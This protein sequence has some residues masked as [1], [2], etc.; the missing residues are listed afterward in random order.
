MG[1]SS[2]R[3]KSGDTP[4]ILVSALLHSVIAFLFVRLQTAVPRPHPATILGPLARNLFVRI[5]LALRRG[6]IALRVV[7]PVVAFRL[8]HRFPPS[9]HVHHATVF[10]VPAF[11]QFFGILFVFAQNRGLF[12]GIGDL[13]QAILVVAVLRVDHNPPTWGSH[14]TTLV[15]IN[16]IDQIVLGVGHVRGKVFLF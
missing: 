11:D 4:V 10:S 5:V 2:R 7:F 9:T 1:V 6:V 13:V 3:L 8:V 12:E 14:F 15:S 16:A